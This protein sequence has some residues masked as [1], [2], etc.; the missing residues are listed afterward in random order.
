MLR[1][2]KEIENVLHSKNYFFLIASNE[3]K[4]M[5]TTETVLEAKKYTL[6]KKFLQKF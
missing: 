6:S 3:Y 5:I 2:Y 1:D 4:I